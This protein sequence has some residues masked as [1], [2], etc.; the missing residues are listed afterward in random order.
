MATRSESQ[1]VRTPVTAVRRHPGTNSSRAHL[2]LVVPGPA[3]PFKDTGARDVAGATTPVSHK[4]EA[5]VWP[6]L[7]VQGLAT[8]I[9]G[10]ILWAKISGSL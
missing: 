7:L 4:Q 9:A 1:P 5:T 10:C 8:L 6:L 2:Y 3:R